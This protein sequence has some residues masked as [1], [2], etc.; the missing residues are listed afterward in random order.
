MVKLKG[1]SVMSRIKIAFITQEGL[2]TGG[3]ER[4]MQTI[5]AN[6]PKDKYDI[7][8]YYTPEA[9]SHRYKY[10]KDHDINLIEYHGKYY[11]KWRYIY[12]RNTDF[13]NI[14]KG[15]Y[16]L[17]QLGRCGYP[18]DIISGI[19]DTPIVD[20][21]HWVA[22][23]CNSYNIS[24]VMHISEFSRDVWTK[25]GGDRRRVEMI[26]LPLY[27]PPFEFADIRA[28]LGLEK[29]RFLFGFHQANRDEIFSDIPLRAYKEIEDD[30]NAFVVC[31]GSVKYRDQARELGLKNV[32][33][34]DYIAD[35]N[36][37]YSVIKS[38]NVYAHG[39]FDG[40]LNSAAIAEALSFGLPVITHPSGYFNGHLEIVT[41]NGFV[42]ND[43]R[44]YAKYMKMLQGDKTL[45]EKCSDASLRI[46][47]DKYDFDGQMQRIMDIYDGILENPYPNRSR[48]IYYDVVQRAG[49][50]IKGTAVKMFAKEIPKT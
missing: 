5:A 24:R 46:F 42:A 29:D 45:R 20:S 49:N 16:D 9:A 48:R 28:S 35:D 39:R 1:K 4:F 3:T 12:L 10:M 13:W 43:Y 38:L 50:K 36:E 32:F 11:T 15:G 27:L 25:K 44:E 7:D 8:Y 18:D 23:V 40:E 47:H 34:Y 19:K 21:I 6:L 22:G 2:N 26:S 30:T 17:I 31:N 14:Y 37:F 33:F 41:D